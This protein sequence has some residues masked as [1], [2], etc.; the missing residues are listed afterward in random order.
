MLYL[1]A[2]RTCPLSKFTYIHKARRDPGAWLG[3]SAGR[4]LRLGKLSL[5]AGGTWL[6]VKAIYVH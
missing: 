3:E 2:S 1:P 6:L 5:A 4:T